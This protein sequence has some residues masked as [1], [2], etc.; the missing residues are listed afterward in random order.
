MHERLTSL[1]AFRG[2]TI[3]AMILV[4]NPGHWGHVY[5]PLQHADWHGWTPADLVFPFFLFIVGTSMV[6][7]FA[8][9]RAAGVSRARMTLRATRR[10]V[11]IVTLGLFI[12]G[13][14]HHPW[15]HQLVAIVGLVAA[16]LLSLRMH[17][18][19]RELLLLVAWS[20]FAAFELQ[21]P[22]IRIPG[23]L[24]RIGVCF[25][26]ASL[27][28]V[29][30]PRRVLPWL[31]AVLLLGYWA[32]M[33]LIPVPGHGAGLLD[34]KANNL[35]SWIDR[36]LLE[37]HLWVE[38]VRDPE[39]PLHTVTAFC[40][41]LLGVFAGEVLTRPAVAHD[42]AAEGV[43][44]VG[45]L[46]SAEVRTLQLFLRGS[47]LLVL[48]YAWNFAFPLNKALW[49]SSYVLFTGGLATM[50]LAAAFWF[51][52]VR[53]HRRVVAPLVTYGLNAITVF[54]GSAALARVLAS[55]PLGE[56]TTLPRRVYETLAAS[57]LPPEAASLGY[58]LLWVTGWYVVLR[59]MQARGWI[60]RV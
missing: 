6:L 59:V 13:F 33:T 36:V 42:R 22:G 31:V 52:D 28:Y 47:G 23:V 9:Q 10:A 45:V 41:T 19:R 50:A 49:T 56:G 3:A 5:A 55:L 2:L 21:A 39:G 53:G 48:G 17:G 25:L 34:D 7:A 1:D 30:L 14:R 11:V 12:H 35:A 44:T 40:T 15:L 26:L 43:A 58:A 37:G 29:W 60:L 57:G 32:A 27:A 38:G 54:V 16:C 4:N 18:A 8:R 46:P 20:A 51:V 24:Q